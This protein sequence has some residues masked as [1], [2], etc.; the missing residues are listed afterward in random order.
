MFSLALLKRHSSNRVTMI[1][2]PMVIA[3]AKLIAET[4]GVD[5][6]INLVAQDPLNPEVK[7]QSYDMVIFNNVT[8]YLST[9]QNV[10]LFRKSY[11]ALVEGGRLVL[12]SPIADEDRKG[13]VEVQL[14]G[15]E[16]LYFSAEETSILILSIAACLRR[17]AILTL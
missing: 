2:R 6:Q 16:M 9:E 10:G 11:E 14:M 4:M 3:Y 1:D 12:H 5:S 15:V 7:A 17:Q 13:P 8:Q